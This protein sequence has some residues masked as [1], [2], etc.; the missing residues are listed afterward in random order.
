MFPIRSA[1]YFSEKKTK[2]F[3]G[4]GKNTGRIIRLAISQK[5]FLIYFAIASILCTHISR[6]SLRIGYKHYIQDW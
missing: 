6:L 4:Y 2:N 5:G 1:I 3:E